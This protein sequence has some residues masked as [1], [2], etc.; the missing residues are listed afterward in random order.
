MVTMEMEMQGGR[1]MKL[2]VCVKLCV[3]RYVSTYSTYQIMKV[4]QCR[5]GERFLQSN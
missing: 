4:V 5:K 1:C 3:G 2:A